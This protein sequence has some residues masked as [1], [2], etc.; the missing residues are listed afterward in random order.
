MPQVF[1]TH[2]RAPEIEAEFAEIWRILDALGLTV[3]WAIRRLERIEQE[4]GIEPEPP[5]G[6]GGATPGEWPE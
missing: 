1:T 4:L 2:A 6:D 3:Q 5:P